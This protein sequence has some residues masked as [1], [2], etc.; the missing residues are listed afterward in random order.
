MRLAI[1][2][3][4]VALIGSWRNDW[5]CGSVRKRRP[6]AMVHCECLRVGFALALSA[7]CTAVSGAR[8]GGQSRESRAP[9]VREQSGEPEFSIG[10]ERHSNGRHAFLL[11]LVGAVAKHSRGGERGTAGGVRLFALGAE[12]A[13]GKRWASGSS[14][15]PCIRGRTPGSI[16]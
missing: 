3:R 16:R 14:V 1:V 12:R 10:E 5:R 13:A 4:K 15:R 11:H 6:P 2:D 9:R 8:L 7:L